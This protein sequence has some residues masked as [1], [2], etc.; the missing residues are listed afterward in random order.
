MSKTGL[1]GQC[2]GYRRRRWVAEQSMI[3]C[4]V[5]TLFHAR[6]CVM[7]RNSKMWRGAHQHAVLH[8]HTHPVHIL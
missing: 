5:A 2:A 7:G 8:T 6:I 4:I 3:S 1:A